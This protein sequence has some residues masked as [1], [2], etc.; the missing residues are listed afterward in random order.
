MVKINKYI[1]LSEVANNVGIRLDS[2]DFN[3]M[4][5]DIDLIKIDGIWYFEY[6]GD[7]NEY[8]KKVSDII[9][10]IC[11]EKNIN[12]PYTRIEHVLEQYG[13]VLHQNMPIL[14]KTYKD[15]AFA[16]ITEC[17]SPK[18]TLY[19]MSSS[20]LNSFDLLIRY[21]CKSENNANI[22]KSKRSRMY[23][24]IKFE[25]TINN[26]QEISD[27]N[28]LTDI[29]INNI[30]SDKNL[31]VLYRK[32]LVQYFDYLKK[33]GIIS[34]TNCYAVKKCTKL[35]TENDFYTI[36]EWTVFVKAALD[37]NRHIIKAMNNLSYARYWL[38]V[39]L[40]LCLAWRKSDILSIPALDN[41]I[42]IE[43][44]DLEWFKKNTFGMKEASYIIRNTKLMAEQHLV[45][46]TKTQI[47][48]VIPDSFQIQVSIAIIIAENWR[49]NLGI[50][51]LFANSQFSNKMI[52]KYLGNEFAAFSNL[53]AN[54]SLLT[55]MDNIASEVGANKYIKLTSYMRSHKMNYYNFSDTT[56]QYLYASFSDNE[57]SE[58]VIQLFDRGLF[59]WL[60]DSMID[61]VNK[62]QPSMHEKT[63]MIVHMQNNLSAQNIEQI[64]ACIKSYDLKKENVINELIHM[65]VEEIKEKIIKLADGHMNSKQND[66]F[67][68]QDKCKYKLKENCLDCEYAIPGIHTLLSV[69]QELN[70]IFDNILTNPPQCELDKIRT[71]D[72]MMKLFLLMKEASN[73]FG[74]DYVKSC[75]SI[76]L[77]NKFALSYKLLT[78]EDD[79]NE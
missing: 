7:K 61:L 60:Y 52:E 64:A 15:F 54:R 16:K 37:I 29:D 73:A 39:L 76:E 1:K 70:N 66:I 48:F 43:K 3:R 31:Q 14:F 78:K 6:S 13:D 9:K 4:V 57:L 63:D 56:S 26:L 11:F 72:K 69:E 51:T 74:E 46:K 33:N 35:K 12:N 21:I 18:K 71:L 36:E 62:E 2:K 30:I 23:L 45:Q 24:S 75:T 41:L 65:P 40:N 55:F 44:Y 34:I 5:P 17:Q 8:L 50:S 42:D 49:R 68:M 10:E 53:K 22:Q 27:I 32:N 79:K 25:D 67:C 38:Y 20:L 19:S 28:L 59:G 47:H 58:I 77:K